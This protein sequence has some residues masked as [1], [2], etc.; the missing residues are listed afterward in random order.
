MFSLKRKRETPELRVA[1]DSELATLGYWW[2]ASY[3]IGKR[4]MA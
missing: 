2:M 3:T 4:T 1:L